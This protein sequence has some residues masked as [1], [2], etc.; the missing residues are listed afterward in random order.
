MMTIM[1]STATLMMMTMM[2]MTIM[3][4]IT[5]MVTTMM[6]IT[7]M[8]ITMMM[9]TKISRPSLNSISEEEHGMQRLF[10]NHRQQ[11][12]FLIM[13]KSRIMIADQDQY[14][15]VS[16]RDKAKGEDKMMEDIQRTDTR[17]A[18]IKRTDMAGTPMKMTTKKM[19]LSL[20]TTFRY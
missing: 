15:V 8:L 20:K 7:K 16:D 19:S 2:L 17:V 11:V 5:M 4:M 9:T 13:I 18:D 14:D 6:M 1:M 12:N 3:M 10:P